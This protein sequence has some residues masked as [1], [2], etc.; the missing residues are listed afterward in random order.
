VSVGV[1]GVVAVVLGMSGQAHRDVAVARVVEA[2]VPV[3][4][5][6]SG[7]GTVYIDHS[8]LFS[9]IISTADFLRA[10]QAGIPKPTVHTT[11]CVRMDGLR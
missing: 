7:G 10:Y 2:G 6:F 8:T 11:L 3:F 5:R 1:I 9:T 4:R